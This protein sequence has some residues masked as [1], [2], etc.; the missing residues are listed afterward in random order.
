MSG[1]SVEDFEAKPSLNLKQTLLH[2]FFCF[3]KKGQIKVFTE[4]V[5]IKSGL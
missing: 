1:R 3:F 5:C 2:F 4:S